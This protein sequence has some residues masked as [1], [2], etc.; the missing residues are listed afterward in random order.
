ML[1]ERRRLNPDEA[2]AI[3]EQM[4]AA[5]AAAHRAGLVHRDVKPENVLVAE[6]P[7]G[8]VGQPGR[9]VVKVADFGLARAVEAQRR[10]GRTATS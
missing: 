10:R 7:T 3:M 6:A 4:L 8:G 1:A 5:I 9:R 2:L